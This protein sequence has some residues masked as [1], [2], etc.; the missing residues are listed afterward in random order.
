MAKINH[1]AI[2]EQLRV[3]EIYVTKGMARKKIRFQGRGR[4]GL[5]LIKKTHVT[6]KVEIIDF[7]KMI[8]DAPTESQRNKWRK[9]EQ[10]VHSLRTTPRDPPRLGVKERKA[11]VNK[12]KKN[13][14]R[15]A[16]TQA[17]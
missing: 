4:H 12:A 9:R 2:P 13:A 3:K 10:L 7:A 14:A 15:D 17:A 16:K 5:G 6:L 8:A 11:Q 1:D